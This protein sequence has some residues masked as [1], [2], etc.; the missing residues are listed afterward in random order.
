MNIS[1][2]VKNWGQTVCKFS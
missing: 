1:L 2:S